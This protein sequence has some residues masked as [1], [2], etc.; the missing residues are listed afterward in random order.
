MWV[1]YS[2]SGPPAHKAGTQLRTVRAKT[3]DPAADQAAAVHLGRSGL[4]TIRTTENFGVSLPGVLDG[5]ST[6]MGVNVVSANSEP[7]VQLPQSE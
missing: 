1:S 7:A 6:T 5:L 2:V 3:R 4:S